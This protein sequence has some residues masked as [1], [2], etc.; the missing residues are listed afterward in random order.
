MPYRQK[1][2]WIFAGPQKGWSESYYIQDL[3]PTIAAGQNIA[4]QVAT[5]RAQMLGTECYIKAIRVQ[6]VEDAGGNKVKFQG[7]T[8]QY[9]TYPGNT[10]H[11]AAQCDLS[12]LVDHQGQDGGRHRNGYLGGIWDDVESEFG[13]YKPPAAFTAAFASWKAKILEFGYGW[14]SRTPSIDYALTNYTIDE[15]QFVTIT[16][17]GTPFNGL[18]DAPFYVNVKKLPAVGGRSALNGTLLVRRL[19]D[20]TCITMN[21]IAVGPF[22]APGYLNKFTYQFR[23]IADLAVEKVVSRERGAPLLESRGR[24]RARART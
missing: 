14:V 18:G 7:D 13:K 8:F 20:S 22:V 19:T 3:T 11:S 9:P 10:G 12:L 16:T 1:H 21:R 4:A 5:V 23:E 15:N 17:G 2:T 24:R 6:E